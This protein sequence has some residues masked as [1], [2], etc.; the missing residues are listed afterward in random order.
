MVTMCGGHV[1]HETL[2]CVN[3]RVFLS[4]M[5]H[6]VHFPPFDVAYQRQLRPG[7]YGIAPGE[8]T[9]GPNVLPRYF[10][11]T[12]ERKLSGVLGDYHQSCH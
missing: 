4:P 9:L 1:P 3:S 8:I 7:H 10:S 12:Q 11:G 5:S 6:S 2:V